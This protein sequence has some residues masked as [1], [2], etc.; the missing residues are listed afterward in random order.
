MVGLFWAMTPLVGVQMYLV[1]FTW[2]IVRRSPRLEFALII[3]LAWT[4]VTNVFT[5]WPIY[6][7]FFITG[8][9]LLGQP[10][11]MP[12]YESFVQNWQGAL[13]DGEGFFETLLAQVKLIAEEKG[14]PLAVG[15]LPYAFISAWLGYRWSLKYVIRR[16]KYVIKRRLAKR[17]ESSGTTT[18]N[19]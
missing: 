11:E 14:L 9:I 8:R 12:G 10:D 5:M 15:S 16:R 1:F 2:L 17:R 6:Y 4:W 13:S 19:L 7:A 18:S 3:G